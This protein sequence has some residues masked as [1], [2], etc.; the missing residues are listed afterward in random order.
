[1]I[2]EL[3][4]HFLVHKLLIAELDE[5]DVMLGYPVDSLKLVD[6]ELFLDHGCPKMIHLL[7][8]VSLDKVDSVWSNNRSDIG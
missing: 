3:K 8:D 5:L 7:F 1:M 2:L 4:F 6:S